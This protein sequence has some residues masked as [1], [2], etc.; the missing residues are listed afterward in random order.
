MAVVPG[1]GDGGPGGTTVTGASVRTSG[2]RAS[3][4][5][6]R[7]A[8]EG[9][10]FTFEEATV[11]GR[12]ALAATAAA[13]DPTVVVIALGDDVVVLLSYQLPVDELV[14]L[15]ADVEPVDAASW[16]AAGGQIR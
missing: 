13:N 7:A 15:A 12:E 1:P 10:G 3:V 4:D 9:F 5:D 2:H 14:A 8:Y 16:V 11:A 6:V